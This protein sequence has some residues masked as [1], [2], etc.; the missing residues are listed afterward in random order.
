MQ[1]PCRREEAL[2]AARGSRARPEHGTRVALLVVLAR[3]RQS[4]AIRPTDPARPDPVGR[5]PQIRPVRRRRPAEEEEAVAPAA[6]AVQ[7]LRK[8]L[9]TS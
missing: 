9:R 1:Q 6:P 8:P 3:T 4:W 5:E 2:S 7:P